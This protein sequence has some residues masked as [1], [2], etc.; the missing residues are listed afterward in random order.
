MTNPSSRN[1][2]AKHRNR[3]PATAKKLGQLHPRNPHQGRYDFEVLTRALPELAKHTITNPKGESTIN[4]S[5]AEAVR[6][7][8]QALLAHYY[9][10]KF[11]D[12]PEG[13]LC[14]PIPG[15]AD[16]IHYIAD[17]LAQT[18]HANKENMPPMGKDIHA[19]DIGTGASAIY[20]IIGSQSYGWRFTASDIDTVSV[21]TATVI[22]QANPKLKGAIKVKLQPE[23]KYIFKNIIGRQD[24]FDVVICNPPFHAS[25]E[26]AME[27][28][29]RKQHNLQR[30]RGKNESEQI[31][32][33]STKSGN[34][35]QNLNFG[36]KHKE[37][38]SEGGEIAFLTK[39]IKESKDFGEHV[40]WFTS[41]VSK[42]ENVKPLQQL[43]KDLDVAQMRIIEMSQGQK[44][45]RVLAWRFTMDEA[46]E[47]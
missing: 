9:G 14:P 8:N 30:H 35:A 26:E 37:L 41:L 44:S 42:S 20:P 19:L 10:V 17:L 6:V 43:L 39:M 18:T 7:L 33:S 40:G 11:W 27:A 45:T 22:S 38:W 36:G 3:S 28:N 47:A 23:P 5:D 12:I 31:S 21:N 29:S 46:E 32:R 1:N 15:R 24:Y 4:F 25:L 16:Y 34:A 13:Y 2:S